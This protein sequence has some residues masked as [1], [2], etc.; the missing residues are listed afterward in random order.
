MK[1]LLLQ[2]PLF[3]SLQKLPV[4]V[5]AKPYRSS[6]LFLLQGRCI[7]RLFNFDNN[8]WVKF[9]QAFVRVQFQPEL[10]ITRVKSVF[11][12]S[13]KVEYVFLWFFSI[14]TF[15]M[16]YVLLLIIVHEWYRPAWPVAGRFV[17]FLSSTVCGEEFFWANLPQRWVLIILSF[18]FNPFEVQNGLFFLHLKI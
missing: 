6:P 15:S 13:W 10:I 8:I 17:T 11:M 2:H 18:C 7:A 1:V 14:D 9:T 4:F 16:R 3:T 5:T 12:V